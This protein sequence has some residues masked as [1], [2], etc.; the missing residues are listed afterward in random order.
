MQS[1]LP[2]HKT[3]QQ[4][5]SVQWFDLMGQWNKWLSDEIV[6]LYNQYTEG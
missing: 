2:K 3:P 4:Q 6:F 5:Q 1:G